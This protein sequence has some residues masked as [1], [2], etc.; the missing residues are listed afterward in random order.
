MFPFFRHSLRE[1][2]SELDKNI[3][4]GP[5]N[6]ERV[7]IQNAHSFPLSL[8]SLPFSSLIVA[9]DTSAIHEQKANLTFKAILE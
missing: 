9:I 1:L 7:A 2:S 4:N 3:I 6:C 5:S 8:F